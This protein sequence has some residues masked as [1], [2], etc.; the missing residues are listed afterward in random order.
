MHVI[1]ARFGRAESARAA[2]AE[3]RD[4]FSLEGAQGAVRSLGSTEYATPIAGYLLAARFEDHE[5][6][7]VLA[8]IR[9]CG[10]EIVELRAQDGAGGVAVDVRQAD[11]RAVKSARGGA[12]RRAGPGAGGR[13]ARSRRVS[14]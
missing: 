3:L 12:A 14:R 2:L 11:Q 10:G 6:A 5:V 4:R 1:G 9:A 8:T 7:E 13:H